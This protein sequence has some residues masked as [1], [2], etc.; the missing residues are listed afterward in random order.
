MP[1]KGIAPDAVDEEHVA[2]CA[3][4]PPV[5]PASARATE[6]VT[7]FLPLRT[8]GAEAVDDELDSFLPEV[9][10]P[11]ENTAPLELAVPEPV[12]TGPKRR[13]AR[14]SAKRQRA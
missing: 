8:V 7:S 14:R 13:S 11:E 12:E 4:C 1:D 10:D 6:R 5:T 9:V 2:T 3:S